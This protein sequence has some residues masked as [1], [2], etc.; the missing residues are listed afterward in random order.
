MALVAIGACA[1]TPPEVVAAAEPLASSV[2]SASPPYVTTS[3][4]TAAAAAPSARPHEEL[5]REPADVT[6]G[7]MFRRA[8]HDGA[9]SAAD[10]EH[11]VR[12]GMLSAKQAKVLKKPD[13]ARV[14]AGRPPPSPGIDASSCVLT[15][16]SSQGTVEL[17]CHAHECIGRCLHRSTDVTI[18][19]EASGRLVLAGITEGVGDNGWCG[20][21]K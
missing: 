19:V 5:P 21:C 18:R 14:L 10:G 20:C 3:D 9:L 2:P 11:L 13:V 8:F 4:V 16:G 1:A 7:E 17:Q 6:R 12:A 15:D